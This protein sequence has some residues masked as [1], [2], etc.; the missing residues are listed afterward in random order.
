MAPHTRRSATAL[1]LGAALAVP[2][3][4]AEPATDDPSAWLDATPWVQSRDPRIVALA[5]ERTTGARSPVEA[6]V[7]LHD[8]VRD[9]I[10]FGFTGAFYRMTATDVLAARVGYCNTKATLFVAL[11]RAAGIP[12]RQRFVNISSRV[13]AGFVPT[14]ATH[15]DHSYVEVFLEGR[16]VRTDSYVVDRALHERATAALARSGAAL[17]FGVHANGT[18]RWDGRQD[19]FVQLV[20]DGR[21]PALT[22]RDYGVFTDTVAFYDAGHGVNR[23]GWLQRPWLWIALLGVERRVEAFRKGAAP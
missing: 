8:F 19:A 14:S 20:D 10:A 23:V 21:V 3:A 17:G 7:R 4:S 16:W 6:A 12:A 22:T 2:A 18:I 11:L 13:L 9:E 15:V 5:R 1:A